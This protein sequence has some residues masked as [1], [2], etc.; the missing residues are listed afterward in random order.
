M[1]NLNEPFRCNGRVCM[2]SYAMAG[3][4][5]VDNDN[6]TDTDGAQPRANQ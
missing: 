1:K 4:L 5:P 2:A 3:G 6:A